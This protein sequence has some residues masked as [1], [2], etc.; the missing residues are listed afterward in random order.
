MVPHAWAQSGWPSAWPGA[1]RLR[2]LSA[3]AVPL[4]ALSA[5]FAGW[6]G[7]RRTA[8]IRLVDIPIAGLP[9]AL[10]G[11]TIVQLSDIHVGNTI[12]R[13]YVEAIVEPGE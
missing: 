8:A 7:A 4:L 11:F 6:L 5:A 1:S 10:E 3:L 13:D 2:E 9:T 12:G